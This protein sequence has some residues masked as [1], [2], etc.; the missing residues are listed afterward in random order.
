MLGISV[1]QVQIARRLT[2]P[3][4][5]EDGRPPR[6]LTMTLYTISAFVLSIVIW[7]SVTQVGE[8][9]IA[10]GQIIPHGQVLTVQHLEGGVVAEILVR[11]GAQVEAHQPLIRLGAE[12]VAGERNQL[13]SRR[14]NLKLQL[15]RLEAQSRNGDPDFGQ[16]GKQFP[17]LMAEQENLFVRSVIQRR[18][19]AA[20]LTSRIAQKRGEL[21]TLQSSLQAAQTQADLQFELVAMQESL[22]HSGLGARKNWIE[23][24]SLHQRAVGDVTSLQGKITTAEDAL[25]EAQ[26]SLSEAQARNQQKL[27]EER[28]KAAADLAETEQQL[29]KF[30]DR[31]E[32]LLIRAP[33]AGVIQEIVPKSAGE[34]I[35]PGDLVARIVPTESELVAEVRIDPK[36]A[37]HVQLDA[38]VDVRLASYDSAVFGPVRGKVIYISPATFAPPA[39]ASS[40]LTPSGAQQP[41]YKATVRLLQDHI[42]LNGRRFVFAAG[43]P[44]QA[45]IKTGSKSIVRYMFKPIFNSLDVAFH[46]R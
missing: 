12:S 43:M 18:E 2:Q 9:A 7:A 35:R 28:A 19:E 8:I 36:D 21:A 17:D 45:H 25:T 13:D 33:S 23:A 4:A 29:M 30:D 26:S 38:D 37:G 1:S 3:L 34:V 10:P 24:K 31:L 39:G 32:R 15:T 11:E 5:L 40:P 16:L 42:D 6:V 22:L 27:G 44:L 46:E 20:I 14:A 41:Y